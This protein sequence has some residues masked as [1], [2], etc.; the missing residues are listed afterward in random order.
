MRV[1]VTGGAGRVGRYVV[2]VL[3]AAG[4]EVTSLDLA[5]PT[6]RVA[7]VRYMIGNVVNVA[8]VY[9]AVSFARV[10]A[11]VHMA[12]WSDPG[13]VAD[14]RTYGENTAAGFAVLDTAHALQVRRVLMASSAQ[15]YG[16]AGHA[17]VYAAVD[18][19]HPLRPLNSYALSKTATEDAAAYFARKGLNVLCLRIMGA[20]APENLDTEVERVATDPA[21]DRFLLWTRT[22]ARDIALGVH[23]ALAAAS[24]ESGAYNLTNSVNVLEEPGA[25]L[26]RRYCPETEVRMMSGDFASPLSIDK[27][28]RAFGYE[29]RYPWSVSRRFPADAAV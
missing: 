15:V 12:A 6:E 5:A 17:P 13:I 29:P 3:A 23:Q 14:T 22:D 16:F 28:R 7:G 10:E 25:D 18:E 20:R 2:R 11:I 8:D 27:A 4:Y 26:V 21:S 1:L 24:V 9:G 19:A